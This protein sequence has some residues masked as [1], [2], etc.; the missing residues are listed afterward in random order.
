MDLAT[1]AM[2]S[3]LPKLVQLLGEE[4]KLHKG[5]KGDIKFLEGELRSMHAALRKV[6]DVQRDQL[7][8]LVKIWADEV[9]DLSYDMEDLA[10][11][12]LV[13]VQGF[14]PDTNSHKLKRL[15]KQMGDLLT[16]GKTRHK[17]AGE[18]KDIKARVKEVADRRDRY[19]VDSIVANPAATTAIDPRLLM[20]YKPNQEIVG[21]EEA[22]D[23][24]IKRLTDG[25]DAVSKLQLKILSIFGFGGLGKTTL[26]KEVYDRLQAQYAC[27]AFV[28]VGRNPDVKKVLKD[29]LLGIDKQKYMDFNLATLDEKQLID[30][31]REQLVN[32]RYF[33]VIDDIW[34]TE[35]WGIIRCAFMDSDCG[36]RIITTTRIFEVAQKAGDVY[37]IKPLSRKK[38]EELFY[39][40]LSGDKNKCHYD[41]QVE[42]SEKI[43]RKCGGVPLAIIA[44]ASLLASKPMDDWSKVY[45]SIGFGSGHNKDVENMRK[46]L[47]YS[48][49]D[50]PSY[51]RTCL[52]HLSIHAEDAYIYKVDTIWKWMAEGFVHEEPDMG[53]F[54]VGKRYFDELINRSMIRPYQFK[55]HGPAIG[56]YVHDMVLDMICSLS[57]E[58]NFVSILGS[59]EKHTSLQGNVRRLAIQSGVIDKDGPLASTRT[60][61]LRLF[62]ATS[63][64]IGVMPPLENFQ[65]LRVLDLYE[66]TY[67][68]GHSCNLEHLGKLLQLRYLGLCG[69]PITKLP[70]EIGDLKFLQTLNIIATRIRELPLGVSLLRQLRCLRMCLCPV[71]V[72]EWI[73][74]LTS[75]EHLAVDNVGQSP[76]FVKELGKLT[77]LRRLIINI[78][79][80]G[81]DSWKCKAFVESL[82][83]LQKIQLL[84]IS[85]REEANLDTHVPSRQL[86]D[87]TL[88]TSSPRLPAW[89]NTSLVPNLTYLSV[90][91][92]AVTAQDVVILGMLPEL[93]T[94]ELLVNTS[95]GGYSSPCECSEGAFPKLKHSDTPAPLLALKGAMPSVESV[96]FEVYVRSL[97]DSNFDFDFSSLGNLPLLE[98]A[99]VDVVCTGAT[100]RE[101]EEAE[102][103][104]RRAVQVHP[105]RPFLVLERMG[106]VIPA[107]S[108]VP[109][110]T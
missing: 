92:K 66:C 78:G 44:I 28:V 10:D 67:L 58:E 3:L 15:V 65:A 59:D 81:A 25:D 108:T 16:K 84:H 64:V 4:Y 73:G 54:E 29:I 6:G 99:T 62:N 37:R 39:T 33:I 36:S 32:K 100:V 90:T 101:V 47:L 60:Q 68:D 94:M 76:N 49:Y 70:G 63:C 13:R 107:P 51:L 82:D 69:T 104:V 31:L 105:N 74:N 95:K 42:L 2:G 75:L 102:A 19:R 48:Y 86:R 5:I 35:T 57:K 87:L 53:S 77:E 23:E 93:L 79:E 9:R 52:L 12:F 46:I 88:S 45:N 21:A 85:S 17:I 11:S 8:E 41:Q 55:S 98:K 34:D 72:P 83:K 22:R 14:E 40:R 20:L 30:E 56:C 103:A 27:K 97:K 7:D 110:E 38:S 71:R 43:L 109:G 26:A 91:L 89:I 96:C 80:L 1:G 50:M 18:I 106:E 24:L 61:Q